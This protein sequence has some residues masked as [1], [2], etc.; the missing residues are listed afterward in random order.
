MALTDYDKK[1]LSASDQKKIQDAT[2]RWNEAN[3]KGDTVG[4]KAA[5][6]EA[7]AVRN[8][9]GYKTDTSGNF[10]G[11]YSPTSNG[12][13]GRTSKPSQFTGSTMGVITNNSTQQSIKDQMNANSIAWW[14]ADETERKRL[15]EEN[16]MLS[17]MLGGSVAYDPVTGIWSGAADG[18]NTTKEDILNWEYD[19]PRP[20]DYESDPRID[21][22]L[23]R[24]LTRD[25]FTYDVTNDPLYQQYAQMYQREGDR[26]MKET[27]AEAAAGAGGMNTYA[28]TAAQQANSYY[29]S[30]LYDKIP[31]LY[32]L[33]Y[34]KYLKDIDLKLQDL[35]VIQD[36]DATQYNR[37]R[38][39]M[40][41][42]KDDRNFA[43][44]MYQDAVNQ[45]NWQANFDYNSMWDNLNFNND[46]YWKD[47]DFTANQSQLELENSRY[48]RET[49]EKQLLAIVESGV[50]PDDAIITQAGWNRATVEQLVA[51]AKADKAQKSTSPSGGGSG[52][53]NGSGSGE[54]GPGK[55]PSASNPSDDTIANYLNAQVEQGNLSEDEAYDLYQ[56]VGF[57]TSAEWELYKGGGINW[58]GGLD[59]NAQVRY[60]GAN[61]RGEYW[62][63]SDLYEELKKGMGET[64]AE[65]WIINLQKDLGI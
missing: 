44:G 11:P 16:Q 46:N 4:M 23:N 5:A 27:L 25:N 29:N 30:Q 61:G 47:K 1:N 14:D 50:M 54:G 28:I 35:G 62:K 12:G 51:Q 63:I 57:L 56:K 10:T 48:D 59:K 42:W 26:A 8:N 41:D 43:Y 31:E 58:G 38:D 53:G 9:A 7:A 33:A 39:T 40:T 45:G 6:D 2:D 18:G 3:K 17:K 49:A 36:M 55:K 22:Y 32:Q 20:A 19:E 64:E 15:E 13:G 37:Y 24:Y 60:V 52:S 21:E 65:K 34:E